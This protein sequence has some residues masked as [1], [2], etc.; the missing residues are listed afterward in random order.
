M[1]KSLESFLNKQDVYWFKYD[2]DCITVA[3]GTFV[4]M[5]PD[6]FPGKYELNVWYKSSFG[7]VEESSGEIF[8]GFLQRDPYSLFEIQRTGI[9]VPVGEAKNKVDVF[10]VDN[11]NI[12][13]DS[14]LLKFADDNVGYAYAAIEVEDS[15][16]S[17]VYLV[18]GEKVFGLI[19]PVNSNTAKY[20]VVRRDV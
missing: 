12:L 7:R 15:G 11:D 9:T 2:G 1:T 17:P 10:L 19:M 8:D 6:I 3:T 14:R 4:F 13:V 5:I 20:K 16:I 18:N